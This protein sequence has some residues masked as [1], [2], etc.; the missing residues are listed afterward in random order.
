[1]TK[2]S[3]MTLDSD[4]MTAFL[5]NFVAG[6]GLVVATPVAVRPKTFAARVEAYLING[7]A[8]LLLTASV[9]GLGFGVGKV[10]VFRRSDLAKAGGI[11]AISD[12]LAEDTAI[13]MALAEIGLKTVF[14]HRTVAQEIV[15]KTLSDVFQRQFRWSVIR[16][17]NERFSYPLE[18]LSSAAPAAP[19]GG[20]GGSSCRSPAWAAF[21]LTLFGWF[22][23]E[24]V[25]A[26]LKGWEISVWSPL[27]FL[28][29]EIVSLAAWLRGWT[30]HDVVWA[31]RRFDARE[32]AQN[33]SA[34]AIDRD[35]ARPQ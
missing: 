3:N 13:S 4:T 11:E 6:V 28:G 21:C 17:A 33:A 30:T 12:A 10:M 22:S 32:G 25:F 16:R 2:D 19:R 7:H 24:M 31:S 23:A 5:Q 20:A 34:P 27:A 9:L 8:R 15:A 26:A 29:R 18:P 1:M 35:D 14:A